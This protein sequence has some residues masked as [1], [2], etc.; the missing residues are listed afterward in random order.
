MRCMHAYAPQD[1]NGSTV[2]SRQGHLQAKPREPSRNDLALSG[3]YLPT[4]GTPQHHCGQH[5]PS[6]ASCRNLIG[7]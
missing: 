6:P 3:L 2:T 4:S 5:I 1:R 7:A